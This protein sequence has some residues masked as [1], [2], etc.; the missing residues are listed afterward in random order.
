MS[1]K[2][3]QINETH[4]SQKRTIKPQMSESEDSGCVGLTF[5]LLLFLA[6]LATCGSTSAIN[7]EHSHKKYKTEIIESE[8]CNETK[9]NINEGLEVVISIWVDKSGSANGIVPDLSYEQ[10]QPNLEVYSYLDQASMS[11]GKIGAATRADMSFL[12]FRKSSKLAPPKRQPGQSPASYKSDLLRFKKRQARGSTGSSF[13]D[14]ISSFEKA[15][16]AILNAPKNE[17]HSLICEALNV[18]KRQF[19][20]ANVSSSTMK[21]VLIFSDMYNTGLENCP[22]SLGEANLIIVNRLSDPSSLVLHSNTQHFISV[23]E[24]IDYIAS[25]I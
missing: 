19:T 22:L 4:I 11:L 1:K 17:P 5:I 16:K 20:Q 14:K 21:F 13:E 7:I 18:S 15:S 23:E 12:S 8:F 2:F 9:L 25:K 24:A 6:S 3:T 10:L